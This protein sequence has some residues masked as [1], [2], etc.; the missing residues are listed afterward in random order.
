M[1]QLLELA[2]ESAVTA[3]RYLKQNV[4]KVKYIDRKLGQETN[5]VTEIDRKAEGMIIERIRKRYP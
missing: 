2:V 3:G 5:L 1:T 4:G